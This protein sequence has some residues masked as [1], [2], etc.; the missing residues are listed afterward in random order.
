M[1]KWV[2]TAYGDALG[3]EQHL[4]Q[5]ADSG[6]ELLTEQD[7]LHFFGDF[8]PTSRRELRY[9]VEA[10]PLFR[11]RDQTLHRVEQMRSLGWD[12]LCTLNGLDVYASAPLRFPEQPQRNHTRWAGV[13]SLLGVLLSLLL[14]LLL[15]GPSWY[16]SNL[17]LFLHT[18]AVLL[19]PVGSVWALWRLLRM[20][21]PAHRA[22]SGLVVLLR[23]TLSALWCLWWWMLAMSIILTLLPLHW[24]LGTLLLALLLR[25]SAGIVSF[26]EG[27][28][29]W[30]PY[31]PLSLRLACL[32]TALLLAIG[33]NRLGVTDAVQD[34][35]PGAAPWGDGWAVHSSDV[36]TEPGDTTFTEY[37]KSGSLLVCRESLTEV[38]EE[39]RLECQRYTCLLPALNNALLE[40]WKAQFPAS[41]TTYSVTRGN[42]TLLLWCERPCDRDAQTLLEGKLT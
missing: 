35:A 40:Q 12:S 39:N 15:P 23:G 13:F 41:G 28:P 36:M 16:L 14:C 27:T 10:A 9:F 25:L 3:L 31:A 5:L 7:G 33:L 26:S 37:R 2:F 24:A 8:A 4:N 6:Y 1:K 29:R 19:L 22:A 17:E 34:Y 20:L 32:G 21:L 38:S 18:S 42:R 30:T 11:T